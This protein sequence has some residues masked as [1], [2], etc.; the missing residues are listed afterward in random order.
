MHTM[1]ESRTESLNETMENAS[2]FEIDISLSRVCLPP[3][4]NKVVL[5]PGGSL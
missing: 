2:L 3:T 5:E 1:T 4:M